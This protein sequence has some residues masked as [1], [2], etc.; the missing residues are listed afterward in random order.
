MAADTARINA[1]LRQRPKLSNTLVVRLAA[2]LV[3]GAHYLVQTDVT[4]LLGARRS[5]H[6]TVAVPETPKK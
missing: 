3:P 6:Q 1:I 2:P 5:S 4:N